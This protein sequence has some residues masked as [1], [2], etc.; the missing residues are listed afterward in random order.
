MRS[1]GGLE[2][3]Q[4]RLEDAEVAVRDRV[5]DVLGD[6]ADDLD[7]ELA[8]RSARGRPVERLAGDFVPAHPEVLGDVA[9]PP[10]PRF[11]Q[12]RRASPRCHAP[13]GRSCRSGRRI[14]RS[15]RCRRRR[16]RESS[17]TIVFSW[18]QC[19]GRSFESS[20]HWIRVFVVSCVAH[21]A[22]VAARRAKE[23]Q[24]RARPDQDA[25]VDPL[26]Q[27]GEQVAEDDLLGVPRRARSRA[28]SASRSDERASAPAAAAAAI[29]GSACAPSISTSTAFPGPRRRVAC[30]P[31]AGRRVERALPADPP[32]AGADD[33]ADLLRELGAEPAL[34][35]MAQLPNRRAVT[36]SIAFG[37][38]KSCDSAR[39]SASRAR[40]RSGPRRR[41]R[42][43]SG[44]YERSTI[45]ASAPSRPTAL[46]R[47]EVDRGLDQEDPDRA[48]TRSSARG[49][50]PSRAG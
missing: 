23:R 36:V 17:T 30:R 41:R 5:V 6:G 12:R 10:A 43:A 29:S 26:G 40:M 45:L 14:P 34:G 47:V 31:A 1:P 3:A 20:P 4:V 2:G 33:G 49:A 38:F 22:H 16:R 13:G 32:S 48:R 9:A 21:R 24:R 25:H 7:I 19:I 18:W 8:G 46:P 37:P 50:R 11:A 28:R 15:G 44:P 35:Q 27:L 42:A 39:R